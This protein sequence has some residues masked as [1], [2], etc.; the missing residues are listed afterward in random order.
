M[1]RTALPELRYRTRKTLMTVHYPAGVILGTEEGIPWPRIAAL[2][3]LLTSE[4]GSEYTLLLSRAVQDATHD[5]H[6]SYLAGL[7][8]AIDLL[9]GTGGDPSAR[10][11]LADRHIGVFSPR[12]A[13]TSVGHRTALRSRHFAVGG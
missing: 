3:Q 1:P 12:S 13:P 6:A 11:A 10:K 5:D 2:I 4:Y 7:N 8:A 9:T